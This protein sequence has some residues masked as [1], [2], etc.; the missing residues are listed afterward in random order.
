VKLL[1]HSDIS[2]DFKWITINIADFN[3][4]TPLPTS[5]YEYLRIHVDKLSPSSIID[6]HNLNPLIYNQHVYFEIRKCMY[7]QPQAGKLSQT[8][9]IQHVSE[10]GYTQCP[11]TP[12]L[13][14]HRT[15]EI[16]R[17]CFASSST[18][19]YIHLRNTTTS[20]K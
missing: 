5:R 20:L 11:N 18:T 19:L 16:M 17:S 4:G 2:G 7:G 9:L 14:R 3:L 13:F 8:R 1:I 6:Q 10:N 12:C 15:Q